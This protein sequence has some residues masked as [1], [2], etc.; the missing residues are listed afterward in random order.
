MKNYL[1]VLL[2]VFTSQCLLAQEGVYD[3][4]SDR[5][6]INSPSVEMLPKYKM[7]ARISHR[8]G[9][10]AGTKGGWSTF[11]GLENSSD[12]SFGIEYGITD[13]LTI[14]VARSKGAGQP[15]QL[16]N[17]S[18]KFRILQQKQNGTPISLVL[19]AMTSIS[20]ASKSDDPSSI[21]FFEKFQH[22]MTDHLSLLAGRKFSER[23]SMQ[24]SSGLT[25]RNVVPHGQENNI[26]D[27]G[28]SF[29]L[30]LSKTLGFIAEATL[31]L[32]GQQSPFSNLESKTK[33]YPPVGV[34][35]AFDTGGHVFQLNFTNA[36][37][38]MPTDYIPSTHSNWLDGQFRMGFTI[39]RVFNL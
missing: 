2:G 28:A 29:R 27:A 5:W 19:F 31:P 16:M 30:R 39:S 4:F 35:L 8:F 13:G 15:R 14:G 9:D 20:T 21:Y 11:Y 25:H 38:I 26:A 23:F 3:I 12:V 32:N 22:R 33:F 24:L 10:I 36:T 17:L 1:F 6:V 18:G 37:G 7:D 34:G